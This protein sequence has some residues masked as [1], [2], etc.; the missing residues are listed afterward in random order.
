MTYNERTALIEA[1]ATVVD[2][3]GFC[4]MAADIRTCASRRDAT[5]RAMRKNIARDFP[6]ASAKF[7]A[8]CDML[9]RETARA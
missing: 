3:A 6:A 7:N 8:A 5:I 9:A 1:I 2:A 4:A